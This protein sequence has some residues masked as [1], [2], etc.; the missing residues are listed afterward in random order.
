MKKSLLF[1]A[2]S[3][4]LKPGRPCSSAY[5]HPRPSPH[6]ARTQSPFHPPLTHLIPHNLTPP[7]HTPK[8]PQ[9]PNIIPDPHN[10]FHPFPPPRT[11]LF[12]LSLPLTILICGVE[13]METNPNVVNARGGVNGGGGGLK[14]WGWGQTGW[15]TGGIKNW[16][17]GGGG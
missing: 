1:A 10:P 12:T 6:I 7:P 16:G 9:L 2:R 14:S 15:Q 11:P 13:K 3:A 17:E 8:Y 4:K 5:V